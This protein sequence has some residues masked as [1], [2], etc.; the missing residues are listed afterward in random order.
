MKPLSTLNRR[1]LQTLIIVP[2][3]VGVVGYIAY[4][5]AQS[6]PTMDDYPVT[7]GI[8]ESYQ[9]ARYYTAPDSLWTNPEITKKTLKHGKN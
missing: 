7:P 5:S 3:V 8:V 6:N 2:I 9:M 4:H 1:R